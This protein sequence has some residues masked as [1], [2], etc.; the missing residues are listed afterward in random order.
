MGAVTAR[1]NRISGRQTVER[2]TKGKRSV[3]RAARRVGSGRWRRNHGGS[4][5]FAL[6][7]PVTTISEK[8]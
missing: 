1:R 7:L 2:L 5:R 3:V 4:I 6:L 8:L